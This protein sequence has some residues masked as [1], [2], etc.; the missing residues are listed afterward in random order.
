MADHVCLHCGTPFTSK[1][2]K[3][4]YC[5]HQCATDASRTRQERTCEQCGK[6]YEASEGHNVR[7]CSRE[8]WRAARSPKPHTTICAHCGKP[9]EYYGWY[10]RITCGKECAFAYLS[11]TTRTIGPHICIVCGKTI[12]DSHRRKYCSRDCMFV[13]RIGPNHPSWRGGSTFVFYGSN[14]RR[15]RNRARKRD[16]Y[17]CQ[18]CGVSES[19]LSHKLDV[20]HIRPLRDFGGD[21]EKANR[22]S[23]LIT[24]CRTCHALAERHRIPIQPMLPIGD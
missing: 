19:K 6:T 16:G 14:W 18:H 7:F 17:K 12:E 1:S 3:R 22:L 10:K 20:H 4:K 13:D 11:A 9:F 2:R 21:Y 24:L 8:C 15:Q 5:C 23:N